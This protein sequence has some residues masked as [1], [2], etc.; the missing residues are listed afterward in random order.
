MTPSPQA[1]WPMKALRRL[2]TIR[3]SNVDKIMEEGEEIVRLCNYV[4][5]YYNDRITGDI[6]FSEGSAKP[7]EITKFGLRTGDVI[8]TKDSETP[9]DI[10]VPALVDSSAEGIV[11]GYHL[12]ILRPNNS[13]IIGPFL[14]WS[15]K[16]KPTREA[17]G[18][19]AQ[20]VTRYGLTLNGIGSVNIPVPELA[21][22]KAIATFLDRE[23]A[24]ID[25]LIVKKER[26]VDVLR[27]QKSAIAKEYIHSGL[28]AGR[29]CV[30]TENLWLPLIPRGWRPRRMRFLF[31]AVKRQG[32]PDL[33]VLSVYRDFGVILK[34]SRDDNINKTPEDL[35]SYQLVEPGDL[36]VN[37]MKAWQGSLGIS[38][39]RG[40]TSPDYLVYRPVAPMNGRYMHHLLRTQPMP[41]LFLT[42]SNGIRIDQWRLEHTKFMD[43]VAWLPSLDEQ[44]EIA[45]AI[46][47]RTAGIER[48][49]K[50]ASDS[51]E[52][53]REHRA[54]LITAAVAGQIDMR[55]NLP[56]VTSPS[57][58]DRFRLVVGAEIIHQ[59]RSN[60][61][62]GRVKL[63][64]ELYLAE[65]HLGISELQGNYVRQAAGPLDRTL[66]EETERSVEAAGFYR[67]SQADGAGTG[68]T[69]VPLSNAGRHG[70]EL[71][72]LLGPR[73]DAL[74][75]LVALLRDFG[76]EAVEAIATLYAVWNDALMDGQQPDDSMIVNGVLT[77]WHEDKG[78]KF[79]DSDLRHW[80]DWMKRNGLTPRGQGPRTAHTMTR[81]MFA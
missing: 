60:P 7:Q 75:R 67:A 1:P 21:T 17:F 49:V 3:S 28:H 55:E 80:L 78:K 81:D 57:D 31:R 35:S 30:T 14:F 77:E 61:K 13:E 25:K 2:V 68:V 26:Q 5:V 63:Q 79:K 15:L 20:G 64:K 52:L 22:Q 51:I 62:F 8:I 16:A 45:A 44:A 58:R 6:D 27:E 32:M 50:S 43:V 76:T 41:S 72:S 40:I 70:A 24:R 23:T 9:D 11:C 66:L 56:A 18:L 34:S 65:A 73:A 46:D 33:D 12:A 47:A 69:Y 59:H 74:G 4:D 53:L 37:K 10:A 38:E 29:D 71:K 54:A 39:L 48:L 19:A 42:I 36:V